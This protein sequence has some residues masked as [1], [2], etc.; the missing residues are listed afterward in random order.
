MKEWPVI[1]A[2]DPSF[3]RLSFSLYD[4][5]SSIYLDG[6]KFSF[7]G[8]GVGFEQVFR[9]NRVIAKEYFEKLVKEYGVN[10]KMFIE[11]IFSEIPPPTGIYSAGLY[12]LDTFILDR[13]YMFNKRCDEI[14][15]LPPSFLMTV[16][17]TRKYSKSDSTV[18]AKYLME[19]VL[20]DRVVFKFKGRLN[21]D[22]A[23]SLIF[24]LRAFVRFDVM[25]LGKEIVGAVPGFYSESEKLLVKREEM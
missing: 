7:E 23:E 20:K 4:G 1:L 10:D 14:Y 16:H 8:K 5:E 22:M 12:S 21:A 18:I 13:L 17:N 19:E 25:G 15:T 2:Q 6:C 24:L 11:K 3:R 9:A